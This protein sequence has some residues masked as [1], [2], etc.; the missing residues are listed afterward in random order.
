MPIM[1]VDH[2]VMANRSETTSMIQRGSETV[3]TQSQT[4][5]ESHIKEAT[6]R[7]TERTSETQNVLKDDTHFDAREKGKNEYILMQ[8]KKLAED[9]ED[10]IHSNEILEKILGVEGRSIDLKV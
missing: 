3:A 10:E 8:K 6:E 1:N 9:E 4:A 7:A 5:A 2:I